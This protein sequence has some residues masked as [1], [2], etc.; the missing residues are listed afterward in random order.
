MQSQKIAL[1][2]CQRDI[3]NYMMGKTWLWW[4]IW[5]TLKPNLKCTKFAFYKAEAEQKIAIAVANI[6]SAIAD[7]NKVKDAH[8]QLSVDKNEV[9]NALNSGG[10]VDEELSTKIEKLDKNKNDLSK[11][12]D[13]T[14]S[15]LRFLEDNKR[16]S[17]QSGG[18]IRREMEK[19]RDEMK[20][21]DNTIEKTGEDI[22][23]R[24]RSGP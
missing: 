9:L 19:V 11:Q 20:E 6:D 13:G 12:V 4:Q 15:L 23:T 7:C 8:A 24:T 3:R 14:S 21:M 2:A 1:Y 10:N 16:A 18:K 5:M 17:E 22:V